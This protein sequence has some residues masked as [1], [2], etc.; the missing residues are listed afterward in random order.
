MTVA[1]RIK[2]TEDVAQQQT[3]VVTVT[4]SHVLL[5][6]ITETVKRMK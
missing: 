6:W 4:A 3:F 5:E 1:T 2:F